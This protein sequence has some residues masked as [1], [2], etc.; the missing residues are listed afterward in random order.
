MSHEDA[1]MA[2]IDIVERRPTLSLEDKA[3]KIAHLD[4]L[5]G[6][7]VVS[8][9][10]NS[11]LDI[12][13]G[14]RTNMPAPRN[15]DTRYIREF[16]AFLEKI[17]F[18]PIMLATLEAVFSLIFLTKEDFADSFCERL[19]PEQSSHPQNKAKSSIVEPQFICNAASIQLLCEFA[20]LGL[21]LMPD[22]LQNYNFEHHSRNQIEQQK[23][24]ACDTDQGDECLSLAYNLL[25]SSTSV[26]LNEFRSRRAALKRRLMETTWRISLFLQ[27]RNLISAR[28]LFDTSS[29]KNSNSTWS[30]ETATLRFL[31]AD[32]TSLLI[33]SIKAGYY[34]EAASVIHLYGLKGEVADDAQFA[35]QLANVST[36]LVQHTNI[37]QNIDLLLSQTSPMIGLRT[38][39]D[40]VLTSVNSIQEYNLLLNHAHVLLRKITSSDGNDNSENTLQRSD[41]QSTSDNGGCDLSLKT[42]C[43]RDLVRCAPVH[44]SKDVID[45]TKSQEHLQE[46]AFYTDSLCSDGSSDYHSQSL[47]LEKEKTSCGENKDVLITITDTDLM[48]NDPLAWYSHFIQLLKNTGQ[49]LNKPMSC[50]LLQEDSPFDATTAKAKTDRYG[51]LRDALIAFS[52]ILTITAPTVCYD[53]FI[54]FYFLRY[55]MLKDFR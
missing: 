17:N 46:C 7:C 26:S 53:L 24:Q 16:S 3:V 27:T 51:T 11:L 25:K 32:P 19:L 12:H 23:S 22:N 1:R 52:D 42:S 37:E 50:I 2:M 15:P 34:E 14:S 35:Q 36:S 4:L 47:G 54:L 29:P 21:E 49:I 31:L 39:L 30:D 41:S 38:V 44:E 5:Y 20:R 33:T 13:H 9:A 43:N 40:L 8:V 6:T 55:F 18:P 45:P 48:T 10:V 28:H